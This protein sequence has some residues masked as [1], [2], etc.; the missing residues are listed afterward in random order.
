MCSHLP[1]KSENRYN[2]LKKQRTITEKNTHL[3]DCNVIVR[4]LYKDCD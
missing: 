3:S 4:L 1:P 2:L